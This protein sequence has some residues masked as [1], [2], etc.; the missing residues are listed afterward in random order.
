MFLTVRG[1]TSD[2]Q[3]TEIN[4]EVRPMT[5]FSVLAAGEQKRQPKIEQVRS[6]TPKSEAQSW[7]WTPGR[8]GI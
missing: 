8:C 1:E 7:R 2:H 4:S 6:D 5:A 3:F